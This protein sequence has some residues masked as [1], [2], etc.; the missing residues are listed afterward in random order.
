MDQN[1][2]IIEMHAIVK[3]KVQ[4]VGFRATVASYCKP[5]D[6]VGTVRNLPDGSV[7]IYVQGPFK[8]LED[9]KKQLESRPGHGTIESVTA[10]YQSP[11]IAYKDF[12]II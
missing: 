10:H 3:G 2:N 7:E 4:G 8:A 1:Q 6:L 5:L 9:F 11:T 12:K